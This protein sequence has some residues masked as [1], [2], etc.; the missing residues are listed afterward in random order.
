MVLLNKI[1]NYF[2]N[3]ILSNNGVELIF[4]KTEYKDMNDWYRDNFE[5][6]TNFDEFINEFFSNFKLNSNNF[7]KP[8]LYEFEKQFN[9]RMALQGG[10]I[11]E[12]VFAQTIAEL[13]DFND[14]FD[15]DKGLSPIQINKSIQNVRYIYFN[16]QNQS[17]YLCQL[18]SPNEPDLI[19]VKDDCL[20][21]IDIKENPSKLGELDITGKYGED[22][23]LI[24]GSKFIYEHNY[25]VKMIKE[26]NDYNKGENN[27]FKWLGKNFKDFSLETLLVAAFDHNDVKNVSFLLSYDLNNKILPIPLKMIDKIVDF[28]MSEL[29]VSGRNHSKVYTMNNLK[30]LINVLGGK[31]E[32]QI[33]KLHRS[34]ILTTL[35]RGKSS[36]SRIK[37]NNI[38]FVKVENVSEEGENIFFDLNSVRQL[39][40]TISPHLNIG[41]DY[42][43]V[44]EIIKAEIPM[45]L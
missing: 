30:S 2:L 14:V 15:C 26:F 3:K 11:S 32:K 31:I 23:K 13:F 33:V 45:N 4:N 18:G 28:S 40:P 41:L 43:Q 8:I 27:V 29:R 34:K 22:G 42:N 24:I 1:E 44:R 19:Y 7:I 35:A 21:K 38:Y 39:I 36:V 20:C 17:S 9:K 5:L 16:K 6:F 25:G 12:C 37:L 10:I